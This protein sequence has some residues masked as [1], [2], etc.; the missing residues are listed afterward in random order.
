MLDGEIVKHLDREAERLKME[1]SGVAVTR[2]DV[3]RIALNE[4]VSMRKNKD[5]DKE[6]E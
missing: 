6:S 1:F 5:T 4:W 2:T 3:V